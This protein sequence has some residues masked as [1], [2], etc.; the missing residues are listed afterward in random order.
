Q[1]NGIMV[2]GGSSV[3]LTNCSFSG[4]AVEGGCC[5]T[6]GSFI[7]HAPGVG[8][9]TATGCTF[10]GGAAG[11]QLFGWRG[12]DLY[13]CTFSGHWGN[14]A[15]INL[16]YGTMNITN[17]VFEDNI[18]G[19]ID[20]YYSANIFIEDTLFCGSSEYDIGAPWNDLGG[21]EFLTECESPV[22]G[23]CCINGEAVEL[24]DNDC[25]R[26]LGEFMGEG[27]DPDQ[28]ICSSYCPSDVDGDGEV[29]V[30]DILIIIT[31]WGTCQ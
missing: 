11:S 22:L 23:A 16:N 5:G 28:V 3:Q 10:S 31:A 21:N 14:G 9:V 17:C 20:V 4:P 29:G 13:D 26:I 27:S 7:Y 15:A 25:E 1:T 30:S 6:F 24:F 8:S 19:C 12:F 2:E 18:P